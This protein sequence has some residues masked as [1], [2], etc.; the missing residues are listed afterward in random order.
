MRN[1][2]IRLLHGPGPC[3]PGIVSINSRKIPSGSSSQTVPFKS[4]GL[5]RRQKKVPSDLADSISKC[6]KMAPEVFKRVLGAHF[7]T[8]W[9]AEESEL[10]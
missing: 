8:V 2:S 10:A 3:D 1:R 6:L 7:G 5:I 9:T 4:E